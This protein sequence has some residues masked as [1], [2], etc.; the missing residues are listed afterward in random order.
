MRLLRD[1]HL[2]LC[3]TAPPCRALLAIFASLDRR[4]GL[5]CVRRYEFGIGIAHTPR[6]WKW[7]PHRPK[8]ARVAQQPPPP[9]RRRNDSRKAGILNHPLGQLLV[10]ADAHHRLIEERRGLVGHDRL[11]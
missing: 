1:P 6:R 11:R 3:R 5:L 8:P 2:R 7:R 4:L 10:G 9:N